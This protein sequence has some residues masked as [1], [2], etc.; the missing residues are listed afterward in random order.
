MKCPSCNSKVEKN[1]DYCATCGFDLKGDAVKAIRNQ[2][3]KD[4]FFSA[5]KSI[6]IVGGGMVLLCLVMIAI[7]FGMCILLFAIR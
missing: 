5:L 7:L 1:D 4:M 3:I 2:K 6:F